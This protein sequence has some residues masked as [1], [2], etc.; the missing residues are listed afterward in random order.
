MIILIFISLIFIVD[1]FIDIDQYIPDYSNYFPFIWIP[2]MGIEVYQSLK[3]LK[4]KPENEI[5]LRSNNDTYLNMLPFIFGLLACLISIVF[6]FLNENKIVLI[7]FF[8]LGL[9][10]ILQGVI[11]I[12]SALIKKENENL[13]FENGKQK[14]FVEIE[15][16]E[17]ILF[18]ENDL[19]LKIKEG[20]NYYFQHLE[21]NQTDINNTTIFLRKY[22]DGDIEVS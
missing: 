4:N 18:T 15:Q 5:R 21:L 9:L 22:F 14:H 19:S 20:K 8:I 13:Y 1:V 2:L 11:I 17:S 16:I 12:P 6:F 3:Y 10:S 7:L